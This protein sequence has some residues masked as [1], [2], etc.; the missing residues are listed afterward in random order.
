M[1]TDSKN[2][3]DHTKVNQIHHF[4][5][6]KR[7]PGQVQQGAHEQLLGKLLREICTKALVTTFLQ[8]WQPKLYLQQESEAVTTFI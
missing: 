7:E 3:C 1:C 2:L 5:L 6:Y 4:Y 8:H